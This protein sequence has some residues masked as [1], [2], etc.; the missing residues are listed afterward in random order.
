[1]SH[2]LAAIKVNTD[3]F[4]EALIKAYRYERYQTTSPIRKNSFKDKAASKV[5]K[6][7][8][9]ILIMPGKL[10]Y[11]FINSQSKGYNSTE[12]DQ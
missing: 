1:M 10:F 5:C 11:R 8:T 12:I 2:K 6:H 3:C 4:G 7:L 9:I